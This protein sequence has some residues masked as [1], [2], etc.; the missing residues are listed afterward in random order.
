M[1]YRAAVDLPGLP[2]H[3]EPRI[4][5][6]GCP[7]S[8]P[9]A[10]PGGLPY[11]WFLAGKPPKGWRAAPRDEFRSWHWCPTCRS[12]ADKLLAAGLVRDDHGWSRPGSLTHS[13]SRTHGGGP[14]WSAPDG[15]SLF[16]V[17]RGPKY[18]TEAEAARA[19]LGEAPHA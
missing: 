9:V 11:A 15:A 18:A 7:A 1:T 4:Y 2:R 19:L 14:W 10:R 8:V 12:W 16:D 13:I 17:A 5:C 6:D 3:P